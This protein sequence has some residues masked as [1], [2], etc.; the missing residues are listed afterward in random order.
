MQSKVLN[1]LLV[2]DDVAVA[3]SMKIALKVMGHAID[4]VHDGEDALARLKSSAAH[5]HILITDHKLAKGT[6]C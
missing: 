4:V 1:I 3:A 2:D 5:Y 6:G